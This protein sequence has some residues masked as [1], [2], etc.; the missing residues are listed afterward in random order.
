M[1]IIFYYLKKMEIENE[2]KVSLQLYY[3]HAEQF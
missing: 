2:L 1:K 3:I